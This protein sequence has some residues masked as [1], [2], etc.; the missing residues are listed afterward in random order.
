MI[1]AETETVMEQIKA[2]MGVRFM[3]G[4]YYIDED[5]EREIYG[6]VQEIDTDRKSVWTGDI[7]PSQMAPVIYGRGDRLLG[8]EMKWGLT[9][10]DGKLLINA[11]AETAMER[12]TFSGSVRQR[13]CVIPAKHF[14]EWNR[15]KQKVTFCSR[16]KGIL[17]MAGFYQMQEDGPHFIILTTAANDSVRPVHERMPLILEREE[18]LLWIGEASKVSIFLNKSSPLLQRRQD[19]EQMSL[20]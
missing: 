2:T 20:F 3:C 18:M 17:F 9:G 1:S 7:Y 4:R 6:I 14:Y 16:H 8:G 15:E 11:R 5:V 13:R 10:R 19:Y 12:P